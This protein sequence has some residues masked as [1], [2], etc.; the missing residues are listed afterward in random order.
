MNIL[1][2]A[3]TVFLIVKLISYAS[4][5]VKK[6]KNK[7]AAFGITVLNAGLVACLIMEIYKICI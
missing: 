7:L 6:K 2:A 5:S 4:W 3:V 1:I